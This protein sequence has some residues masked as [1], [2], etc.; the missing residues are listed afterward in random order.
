MSKTLSCLV[1]VKNGTK[2][3]AECLNSIRI[4]SIKVDKIYVI[5]DHSTDNLKE[6]LRELD[7]ESTYFAS[8]RNG[9]AAALNFGIGL[10]DTDLVSFLDSDD[11]WPSDHVYNLKPFFDSDDELEMTYGRVTNVDEDLKPLLQSEVS[12]MLASSIFDRRV[13]TKV[14][15]FDE[16]L[17]HGPNIDFIVRLFSKN[18]KYVKI[19]QTVLLRRIHSTNMGLDTVQARKSL[20]QLIRKN[21]A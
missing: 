3:L 6:V 12:R 8:P 10:I 11:V 18:I 2:Y 20:I 5:D 15:P 1:P 14:G 19:D 4:Q 7:L 9:L 13:F 16:T 17:E 21:R